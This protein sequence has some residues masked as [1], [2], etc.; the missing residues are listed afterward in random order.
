MRTKKLSTNNKINLPRRRG[1]LGI[2]ESPLD[3]E[4]RY[5]TWVGEIS[6]RCTFCFLSL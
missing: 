1:E 2:K 5:R 4:I 6:S 3:S